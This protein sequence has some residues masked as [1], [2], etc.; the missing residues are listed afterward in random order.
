[1]DYQETNYVKEYVPGNDARVELTN[2]RIVDVV[3]GCY[4]DTGVSVAIKGAK[5]VC[6]NG[7]SDRESE[8]KA[9]FTIDLLGKTVMPGLLNTHCHTTVT[10]PTALPEIKDIRLFKAN[11]DK[12]LEKNM[13]ECLIHGITNLRDAY[14]ED[15]N[16]SRS[17]RERIS[18][19]DI[20]GPRIMQAVVVGP[21]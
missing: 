19:G 8:I 13:A 21:P 17:I 2:G 4:F 18:K 6:L 7:L 12:Q 14:A 10:S 9:D 1:M 5:I 3:N 11:A 16:R 15:L 20:P